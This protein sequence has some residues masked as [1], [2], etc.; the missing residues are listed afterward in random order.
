VGPLAEEARNFGKFEQFTV[1]ATTIEAGGGGECASQ[2]LIA[3]ESFKASLLRGIA[4][5]RLTML[6]KSVPVRWPVWQRRQQW[7]WWQRHWHWRRRR[8]RRRRLHRQRGHL[9]LVVLQ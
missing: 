6:R 3:Q 8:R 2:I 5:I 1:Y 9:E 7:W 4:Q